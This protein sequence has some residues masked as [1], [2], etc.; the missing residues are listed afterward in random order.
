MPAPRSGSFLTTELPPSRLAAPLLPMPPVLLIAQTPFTLDAYSGP[1][2]HQSLVGG[3][4]QPLGLGAAL[5]GGQP[6]LDGGTG[7]PSRPARCGGGGPRGG[8]GLRQA[9][10]PRVARLPMSA[11]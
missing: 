5:L 8:G 6:A 9:R 7:R 11:A 4:A 3:P 2:K 10:G 1:V